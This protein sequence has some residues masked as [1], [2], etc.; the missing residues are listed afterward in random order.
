MQWP[1]DM[2]TAIRLTWLTAAFFLLVAI[3]SGIGELLGWWNL[4]GELGMSIGATMSIATTL[5]ALVLTAGRRQVETL[6]AGLRSVDRNVTSVFQEVRSVDDTVHS[7]E[8]HVETNGD[9]LSQVV[10]AVAGED[11]MLRELD[12]IELELD[13]QT[14]VLR[15]Q[16]EVLGDVRDRL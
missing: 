9:R 15:E 16:L 11:G 13:A 5:L 8:G 1:P 4:P 2:D 12:A 10:E 14:G 7:V 3:V 6:D